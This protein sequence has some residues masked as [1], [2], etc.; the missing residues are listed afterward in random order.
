MSNSA[1]FEIAIGHSDDVD[2]PDAVAEA[3]RACRLAL[4]GAPKAVILFASIE[5]D[6]DGI[7]SALRH[8]LPEARVIGCSGDGE[9][10]RERGLCEDSVAMLAFGGDGL[11]FGSAIAE[12]YDADSYAATDQAINEALGGRTDCPTAAFIFPTGLHGNVDRA[13]RA[14]QDRFGPDFPVIGGTAGDHWELK[15]CW[16]FGGGRWASDAIPVLLVW[17]P[18]EFGTGVESGWTR[19]GMP[20]TVTRAEGNIV[21]EIDGKPAVQAFEAQFGTSVE[22][23]IAELPL[24]VLTETG[25]EAYLR[26]V[27][28]VDPSTGALV[29]AAELPEG[30]RVSLSNSTR[31]RILAGARTSTSSAIASM[32]VAP[33]AVLVI[34]CAA[35]KW[36]LGHAVQE[37]IKQIRSG[38]EDAGV[39]VPVVGFYAFGEIGPLGGASRFHNETCLVVGLG[40]GPS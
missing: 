13:L 34:S 1:A 11:S 38:L 26:A 17:G 15:E 8:E 37:E 19:V 18:L 9:M 6:P 40:V 33:T 32:S 3:A 21:Y 31:E 7:V 23:S 27:Y 39:D 30:A 29:M 20:L 4:G 2:A 5:Y 12:R 16:S 14:F 24:A 36:L 22:E 35:R 28:S 10:S 25:T